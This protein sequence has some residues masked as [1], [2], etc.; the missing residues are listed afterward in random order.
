MAPATIW[1]P[2]VIS[3]TPSSVIP[4]QKVDQ[5]TVN[6]RQ[7]REKFENNCFTEMCNGFEAGSY[8]RL[9]DFAYHS[10]LGMRV[11]KKKRRERAH[12][13][14]IRLRG[15]GNSNSHGARSVH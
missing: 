11:I 2:S 15:K 6:K 4:I 7:Q 8:L 5:G 14:D 3:H 13:P 10:S 1:R 9:T 12:V